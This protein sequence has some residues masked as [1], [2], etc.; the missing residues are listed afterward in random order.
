MPRKKKKGPSEAEMERV[1]ADPEK[2]SRKIMY[3]GDVSTPVRPRIIRPLK[4]KKRL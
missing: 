1:F 2:Y 3:K 4:K